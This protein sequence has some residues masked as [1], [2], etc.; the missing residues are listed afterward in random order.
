VADELAAAARG[1][2]RLHLKR[3]LCESDRRTLVFST[4][5]QFVENAFVSEYPK[6]LRLFNDLL[7]RLRTHME[8]KDP[9]DHTRQT[10]FALNVFLTHRC[11]YYS[12]YSPNR[13]LYEQQLIGSLSKFERQ[14]L[15]RSLSHL[16]EPINQTFSPSRTAPTS[17]DVVPLIL[18]DLP[19]HKSLCRP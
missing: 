17:E 2:S 6:L 13:Q 12:S 9:N 10:L 16:F 11:S 18:L 19:L 15:T 1:E 14:Y 4:G 7:K 3:S 8:V 5:S